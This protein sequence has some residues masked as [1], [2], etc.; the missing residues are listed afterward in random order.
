[1]LVELLHDIAAFLEF[2]DTVAG[3]VQFFNIF[4]RSHNHGPVSLR[5]GRRRWG[6]AA[7]V[8]VH[9]VRRRKELARRAE[10]GVDKKYQAIRDYCGTALQREFKEKRAGLR[11]LET[12]ST[13]LT[14]SI[15]RMTENFSS[16]KTI[17]SN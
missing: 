16:P 13:F 17:E 5:L 12:T 15:S 14:F 6:S 8:A 7:W 1:M 4:R 11:R 10:K 2:L 3:Q 9:G